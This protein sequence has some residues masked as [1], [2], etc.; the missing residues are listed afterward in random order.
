MINTND[1]IQGII[2]SITTS[3]ANYCQ[4]I[5]IPLIV[6]LFVIVMDYL[7]GM[8][9]AYIHKK[10]SSSVGIK[11]I[12]KKIGYFVAVGVGIVVD[13]IITSGLAGVGI[14]PDKTMI[15]GLIVTTWSIINELISILENLNKM[16]VTLPPLLIKLVNRLKSSV[17]DD[18]E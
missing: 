16:G 6:L 12:I 1:I 5:V 3:V 13:Y 9:S 17:S 7:T 4:V 11:G 10:L 14:I 15:V 8:M 18:L 2:D